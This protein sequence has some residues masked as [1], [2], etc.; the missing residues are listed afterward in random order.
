MAA[1][2]VPW[3]YSSLQAFETCPR[4]F[5]LT[6]IAKVVQEPQSEAMAFGNKVHKA[7][8]LAVKGEARLPAT[9]A[10]Y[11]PMVTRIL[12]SSGRKFTEH[13][14]GITSSFKPTTFF[15]KD[16]WF[17]GVI[18]LNII[19]QKVGVTLD[20]KTGKPKAD[21]DQLKLFA[22]TTFA[23]HPHLERVKTGYLWMAHDKLDADEYTPADVPVIWQEFIPRVQRMELA[24][25]NDNWPPR[26]SGLC[27]AWC[28]VGKK[29][30]EF[31]GE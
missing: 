29:N 7:L 25:K 12:Q 20:Y 31:C 28:P 19:G 14:F 4:R 8:E 24:Q 17:R 15:A 21:G 27:R 18:D 6:R 1:N 23:H 3:S 22:V 11:Q 2:V 26:P 9:F 16:V 5:H 10:H 30:C 13:K